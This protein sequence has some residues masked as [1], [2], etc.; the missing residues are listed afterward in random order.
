MECAQTN[1]F[2]DNDYTFNQYREERQ[3]LLSYEDHK[4]AL[5]SC[6]ASLLNGYV[7]KVRGEF[8]ISYL[9]V[10]RSQASE[11]FGI[12]IQ[13]RAGKLID[14]TVTK[15]IKEIDTELVQFDGV[16]IMGSNPRYL[17]LYRPPMGKYLEGVPEK[18]IKFFESR[19]YN[20]E[21][22]HEEFA[23]HAYHLRHPNA[24]IEK[25]FVHYSPKYGNT[26]KSLL[27][28]ILGKMYH[29]FANVAVQQQQITGKFTGWVSDL[30]MVHVE[31]LQNTN[32][33]NHEFETV[34]KQI[35]TKNGSG[36]KK[37][38]D[39]KAGEHR[40]I[41]G[42]NTNQED[43]YGLI[44]ADEATIS[45]LVILYFKPKPADLNWDEFKTEIKLN[46]KINTEQ[47][48]YDLGYS[49]YHYLKYEYEIPNDFNP[50]RYYKQEKYDIIK[51]LQKTNKNSIDS[52]LNE[53]RYQDDEDY[54]VPQ[55]YRLLVRKS[56]RKVEFTCIKNT[57]RDINAS[58]SY[59][60]KENKTN[61]CFKVDS[62]ISYLQEKGFVAIK[63]NGIQWLRLETEKFKQLV[64]DDSDLEEVEFDD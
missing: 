39:V 14:T 19:V 32:Y 21:A 41:V 24:F 29:N 1:C 13:Y 25:C 20:P 47:D 6:V 62:I 30:L 59:F 34:I 4:N 63:S 2:V 37:N 8:G 45:R 42:F 38:I 26:G 3:K 33:R 15:F 35:T 31:E 5:K 11:W 55:E 48:A 28:A 58:Y 16:K 9:Q 53:L 7:I 12:N 43:L 50:C 44:R 54:D 22:L 61:N 56:I 57:K 36:E 17:N 51:Q 27:A 64:D 46:D 40:A 60:I 52:W 10:K 18:V 49:M 23:S